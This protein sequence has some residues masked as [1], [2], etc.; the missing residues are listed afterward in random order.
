MKI[1]TMDRD[2]SFKA[3]CDDPNGTHVPLPLDA[4]AVPDAVVEAAAK[5]HHDRR[6]YELEVGPFWSNAHPDTKARCIE[7]M[8]AAIAAL[9]AALAQEAT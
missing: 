2:G 4:S 8:R 3:W 1:S 7:D 5:T 9:A 6:K